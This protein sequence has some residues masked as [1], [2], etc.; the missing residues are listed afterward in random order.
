MRPD[1]AGAA[2]QFRQ[3]EASFCYQLKIDQNRAR[4]PPS[5]IQTMNPVIVS[6]TNCS[7]EHN[8]SDFV[9][10]CENSCHDGY[11]APSAI[12]T[13]VSDQLPWQGHSA[14]VIGEKSAETTVQ[15]EHGRCSAS[16]V[17]VDMLVA[18]TRPSTKETPKAKYF[19]I[20]DYLKLIRIRS[21]SK[22][23]V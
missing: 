7:G 18:A 17:A 2:W 4:F 11:A 6:A 5:R 21:L 1:F 10:L 12:G 20:L 15:S 19:D 16:V 23:E 13:V 3:S 14:D 22:A 9:G 8:F